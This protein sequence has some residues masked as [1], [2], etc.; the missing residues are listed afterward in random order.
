MRLISLTARGSSLDIEV[1]GGSDEDS[2][3]LLRLAIEAARIL[4][5]RYGIE[6][7]VR[8]SI[9]LL[10]SE[11]AIRVG[12]LVA[13]VDGSATR[14]AIVDL[15]LRAVRSGERVNRVDPGLMIH[16]RREP[17]SGSG[18]TATIDLG[19]LGITYP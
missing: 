11:K 3:K 2:F 18:S 12:G 6:A 4:R 16:V 1:L 15:V 14:E 8:P 13:R 10:G 5:S 19:L 9:D 7:Y 17:M